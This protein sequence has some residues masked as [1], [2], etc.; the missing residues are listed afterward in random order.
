M[1]VATAPHVQ[2]PYHDIALKVSITLQ[3]DASDAEESSDG[4]SDGW[5]T[6]DEDMDAEAAVAKARAAAAAIASNSAK[7]K[8]GSS[9]VR[10][11]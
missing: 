4:S 5:H 9:K 2:C 1:W 7:P 8:G 10:S 3:D 6:D 11:G